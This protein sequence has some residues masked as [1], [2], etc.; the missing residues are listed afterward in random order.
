MRYSD[1][2]LMDL[3]GFQAHNAGCRYELTTLAQASRELRVV[4]LTDGL[5]DRAAAQEAIASARSASHGSRLHTSNLASIVKSW[6]TCLPEGSLV[7]H[8]DANGIALPNNRIHRTTASSAFGSAAASLPRLP[9]TRGRSA[10]TYIEGSSFEESYTSSRMCSFYAYPW[11]SRARR[12]RSFTSGSWRRSAV[13]CSPSNVSI[14][15]R[16]CLAL[17]RWW[18]NRGGNGSSAPPT[19][20]EGTPLKEKIAVLYGGL[21]SGYTARVTAFGGRTPIRTD[22]RTR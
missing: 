21:I 4:A 13:T 20:C 17:R 19:S 1:V 9:V 3:R 16:S 22:T 10:L 14:R 15:S 12:A 5:T 6:R 7:C 11:Q 18:L 2:V 8:A